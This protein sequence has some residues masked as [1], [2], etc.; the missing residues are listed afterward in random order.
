LAE[1]TRYFI[2]VVALRFSVMLLAAK[3]GATTAAALL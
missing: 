3:I 1:L 2:A